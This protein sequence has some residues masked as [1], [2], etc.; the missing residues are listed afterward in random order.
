MENNGK[1]EQAVTLPTIMVGWDAEH[2]RVRL[3]VD[4]S[5][6]KNLGFVVAVLQMAVDAAK[7]RHQEQQ[8]MQR[9]MRMQQ[10]QQD[11]AIAKSLM[12]GK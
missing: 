8:A 6:F 5:Q 1:Q 4:E 7:A 3:A 10:Q 12:L 9:V 11:Q 2:Q